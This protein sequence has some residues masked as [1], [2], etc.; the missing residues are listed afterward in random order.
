MPYWAAPGETESLEGLIEL[1]DALADQAHDNYG[2]DC[3]LK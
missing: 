2:V 1:T 3:L